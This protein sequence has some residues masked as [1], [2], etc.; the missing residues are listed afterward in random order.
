MS[1]NVAGDLAGYVVFYHCARAFRVGRIACSGVIKAI[2]FVSEE[3]K[4][5]DIVAIFHADQVREE[6]EISATIFPRVGEDILL[7]VGDPL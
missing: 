5:E 1:G 2:F 7:Q 3:L 6:P 4:N